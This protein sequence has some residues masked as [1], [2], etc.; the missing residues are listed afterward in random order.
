MISQIN[1]IFNRSLFVNTTLSLIF[2]CISYINQMLLRWRIIFSIV[3]IC[4]LSF[5]L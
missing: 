4:S 5:V 2:N 1:L 3:M